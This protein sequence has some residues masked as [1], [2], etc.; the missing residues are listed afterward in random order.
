MW[1]IPACRRTH[2][3]SRLVWSESWRPPDAES[4]F[5]IWTGWTLAMALC[6][7]DSTINNAVV[8]II[9]IIIIIIAAVIHTYIL[10][11]I[12]CSQRLDYKQIHKYTEIGRRQKTKQKYKLA[13]TVVLVLSLCIHPVYVTGLHNGI[14]TYIWYV[15][16]YNGKVR[17][18]FQLVNGC[19]LAIIYRL[20][21][22][23]ANSRPW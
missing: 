10:L 17:S 13:K 23:T 2:S 12:S 15:K 1:M 7:D 5:I 16:L 21:V 18:S 11:L 3:P 19:G 9:I 6:H 20:S 14:S 8:I 22:N 4:A